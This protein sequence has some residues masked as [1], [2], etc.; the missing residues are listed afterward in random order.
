[1][2][3]AE[4]IKD[5]LWAF[6]HNRAAKLAAL[7]VLLLVVVTIAGYVLFG[8]GMPVSTTSSTNTATVN[9]EQ[10][11]AR[12]ID[13]MM[14]PLS[15][16][17]FFPFGVMIENLEQ[18]R[19][20]AG[21]EGASVVYEALAEGG[22]T[23]FLA[24]FASGADIPKIGPVRSARSYFLD[25]AAEYDLLYAH[26]GGSPDAVAKI[27]SA[28]IRDLN[29]F[30]KSQYY[31]RD[32]ERLK[33]LPSEHTLYTSSELMARALRDTNAPIVGAYDPWTF[34]A[35][36]ALTNRPTDPKTIT[37]EFSTFSYK[38]DWVYDRTTNMY[39]RKQAEKPH[40]TESGAAMKAK[41]IVVAYVPTS[42]AAGDDKSRLVMET[43]GEGP[44]IIFHDGQAINATWKKPQ[45]NSRT[46]F[47]D[48]SGNEL[49]FVKG[50][51]W[52]EIVPSDREVSYN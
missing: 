41:N 48:A 44:A 7:I 2:S 27:K 17:N 24:V 29:Q 22:I 52:I 35:D 5:G 9:E 11:S 25:W 36:A 30:T 8:G 50:N 10:R 21:L 32:K 13:G 49:A 38:V 37:I 4:R 15:G 42:L 31:W 40:V 26:A 33:R 20:Q 34:T 3:V 1:M 43:A 47:V 16:A 39:E 23:R 18:S 14:V 45:R 46:T 12:A 51:T 19:P 6:K 28:N